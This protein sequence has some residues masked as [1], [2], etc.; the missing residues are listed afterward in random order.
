MFDLKERWQRFVRGYSGS[1]CCD[2]HYWFSETLPKMIITLRDYKHGYPELEF[3]EVDNF[4]IEWIEEAAK[5][6]IKSKVESDLDE[7]L[8]L[9]DGFDRWQLILTRIAWCLE[10]IEKDINNEYWDEYWHGNTELKDKWL[11][12]EKE[13]EDYK[14]KCKDEAFDLLKKYFWNLWD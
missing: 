12:K 1:D 14:N 9:K 10:E 11:K 6:I 7:E 4:S 13:I 2:L 8:D 5:D 3:E